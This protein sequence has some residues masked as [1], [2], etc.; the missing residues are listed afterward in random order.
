MTNHWDSTKYVYRYIS[1]HKLNKLLCY[2]RDIGE[3]PS[4][5]TANDYLVRELNYVIHNLE[6]NHEYEFRVRAQNA[7]GLSKPSMASNKLKLKGKAKVPSP[8]GKP[9]VLKVGR[10]YADLKWEPPQSDGGSK[11]TGY[12]VEKKEVGSAVWSKC[13]DY[14]V[15]GWKLA[16][17]TVSAKSLSKI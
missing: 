10:H 7:A 9:T 8:P 14:S 16:V 6:N 4:W 3:D 15:W 11:I 5:R 1:S 13:S 2:C 17:C 12:I